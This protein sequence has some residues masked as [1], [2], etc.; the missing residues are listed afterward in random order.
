MWLLDYEEKGFS[1]QAAIKKGRALPAWY[2][3][4]P[5]LE[6]GEDFYIKAFN[7][8]NTCRPVGLSQG[9]IPWRDIHA[10]AV[11]NGLEEDIVEPFI[12]IIRDMD[13]AFLK[14]L[15]LKQPGA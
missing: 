11:Y 8:L 9:S 4:E 7:D 6:P 2:L 14:R 13:S 12:E 1:V 5:I 10:Y 3:D 15:K